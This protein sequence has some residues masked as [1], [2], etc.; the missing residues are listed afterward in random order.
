M[1]ACAVVAAFSPEVS[2]S[3]PALRCAKNSIDP[4]AL[5]R[6]VQR[7][8]QRGVALLEPVRRP[9]R[10]SGDIRE[11]IRPAERNVRRTRPP[12]WPPPSVANVPLSAESS[13]RRRGESVVE[14]T[15]LDARRSNTAEAQTSNVGM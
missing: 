5:E 6:R 4:G 14:Q 9:R 10:S 11:Q 8:R 3:M 1:D 7:H 12:R 15:A 13:A 2:N